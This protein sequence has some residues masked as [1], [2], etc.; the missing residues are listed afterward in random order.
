MENND[1]DYT[2]EQLDLARRAIADGKTMGQFVRE[3]DSRAD[4]K[5][6][7]DELEQFGHAYDATRRSK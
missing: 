6:T 5:L 7:I 3:R 1:H 2:P 4:R